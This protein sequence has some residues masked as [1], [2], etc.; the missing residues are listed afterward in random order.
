MKQADK[1]VRVAVTGAAGQ[2]GYALLFR[3]AAGAFPGGGRPVVLQLLEVTPAL[4]AL[5]GVVMELQDCAFPGL[6][7]I[8]V[9]DKPEVAF[10]DADYAFLIG[11]KPRGPGMERADLLAGNAA[12]F[13]AQGK[14]LN[15]HAAR[16]VRVLVIGNPANTNAL[17]T[18]KNA[19]DLNPRQIT[20]MMRLD[21]NRAVAQLAAKTAAAVADIRRLTVWGNHSVTQYPDLRHALVGGKP[22][23]ELVER[24][25]Y[26]TEY[27]PRVA[28]RGAEIIQ[29]RGASS[30]AS[31]ANAA[32]DAMRDWVGG[33][34][35]DDWTSMAVPA[36]GAYGIDADIVYGFPARC[37]GGDY[38]IVP[39]L[40]IDEFS[41]ARM[42]AT[43]AE[44]ERE[45]DAIRH[46]LD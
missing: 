19:P 7:S 4:P 42:D 46:L 40:E 11:A 29:A 41:R 3:L 35:K 1:P 25:W 43:R 23:L 12:I 39:G 15:E 24:D 33:T 9:S 34:G 22:A 6:R 16:A 28:K 31:A 45:R 26:E 5:Q 38:E 2:I 14:A 44:L 32:I 13:A 21:H 10:R 20:A 37:R 17:I 8:V 36:D 27:I 18:A 30:A